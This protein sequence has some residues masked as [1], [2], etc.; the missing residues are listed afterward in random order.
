MD[1]N[2]WITG[3]L[4]LIQA[5]CWLK[6]DL[7]ELAF[8]FHCSDQIMSCFKTVYIE[9]TKK[10]NNVYMERCDVVAHAGK[11]DVDV[12]VEEQLVHD[13]VDNKEKLRE[14][15]LIF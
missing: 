13:L 4:S 15:L 7:F 2:F 12:G 9:T 11:V 5:T 8:I 6:V 1:V 14:V 3:T 10:I